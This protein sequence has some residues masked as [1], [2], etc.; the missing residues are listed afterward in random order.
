[1]VFGKMELESVSKTVSLVGQKFGFQIL[2]ALLHTRQG[3]GFNALLREIPKITPRTLSL[4]LKELEGSG[5]I[6]K[7]I[8][9]GKKL[10]IEYRLTERGFSFENALE[11][12]AQTGSKL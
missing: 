3:L 7:N 1:M 6:S 10:R 12:L 2:G 8:A 4:R 11:G 5:L 9:V